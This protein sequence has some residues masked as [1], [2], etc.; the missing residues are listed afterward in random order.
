MSE[1]DWSSDVCSSDLI[2]LPSEKRYSISENTKK[3]LEGLD[4]DIKIKIYLDG[5]LNSGFLRLRKSTKELLDEFKIY[6][7]SKLNYEFENPSEASTA[8]ERDVKYESLEKKGMSGTIVHDKDNEGKTIQKIIYPWAE[9]TY[10][11]KTRVVKLLKNLQG[12]SGDE[13]LNISIQNLEFELTD[14]I[15]ILST[16]EISKIALIEGHGE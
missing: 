7:D 1:C 14:A 16:N 6:S 5:D 15:R 4:N 13:N 2:Y 3:I 9:I 12:K 10:G 8:K 11:G